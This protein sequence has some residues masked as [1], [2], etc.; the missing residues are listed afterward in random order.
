MQRS[1]IAVLVLA[2]LTLTACQTNEGATAAG[3]S[4]S[5]T[6]SASGLTVDQGGRSVPGPNG[7]RLVFETSR[8]EQKKFQRAVRDLSKV[9]VWRRLV[10]GIEL[11]ELETHP[12]ARSV[13]GV[14]LA[15]ASLNHTLVEGDAV[16]VCDI[17]FYP[18][19]IRQEL[20]LWRRIGSLG[21]TPAEW[22]DYNEND[23]FDETAPKES[24]FWA[25][26]LAH[27]LAHCHVGPHG[28]REAR[29]WEFKTMRRLT[30]NSR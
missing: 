16:V 9:H 28:E 1:L 27:E 7:V 26:I 20:R 8:F 23:V 25:A 17:R 14:H 29:N 15:D 22:R 24:D 6:P 21:A 4:P 19:A 10:R 30:R 2:T 12:G 3:P 13:A 11:V 18:R 5:P